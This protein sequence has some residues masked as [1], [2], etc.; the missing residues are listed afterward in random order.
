MATAP[1]DSIELAQDVMPLGHLLL[2]SARRDPGPRGADLPRHAPHLRRAAE[3]AWKVASSLVALGVQPGEHVG[4]L[5]TNH[6][7]IVASFFG[8]S[9]SG[10]TVV[11]INARYRTAE[12]GVIVED[13]DMVALLTHDAA[14]AH[15]DFTALLDAAFADG[16]RPS[17]ATS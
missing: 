12:L 8:I 11:P 14:D 7:D 4:I 16:R 13:A 2:R 17:C 6:P 15:V 10:A 5:M 9:L 3:R 1:I